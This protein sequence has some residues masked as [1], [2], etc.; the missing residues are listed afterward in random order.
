MSAAS[1]AVGATASRHRTPA[2]LA[3]DSFAPD[4]MAMV[5]D[6]GMI[7]TARLTAPKKAGGLG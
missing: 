2:P 7:T 6:R 4:N 3:D 1:T 5:G